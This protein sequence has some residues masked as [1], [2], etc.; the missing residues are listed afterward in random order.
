MVSKGDM[1]NIMLMDTLTEPCLIHPTHMEDIA[2][3]VRTMRGE[4]P[5]RA[6]EDTSAKTSREASAN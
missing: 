2:S 4:A 3:T 1:L 5:V 6:D